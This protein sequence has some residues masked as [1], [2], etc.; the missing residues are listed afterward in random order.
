[1]DTGLEPVYT[2]CMK[3]LVAEAQQCYLGRKGEGGGTL[4]SITY[5]PFGSLEPKGMKARVLYL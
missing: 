5:I 3:A 4:R 2:W 1:M